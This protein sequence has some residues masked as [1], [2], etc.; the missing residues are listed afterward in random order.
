[1]GNRIVWRNLSLTEHISK[2]LLEKTNK[3]SRKKKKMRRQIYEHLW[4]NGVAMSAFNY[5]Q[6]S[7]RNAW[8]SVN[9]AEK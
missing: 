5:R 1:M 6:W 2:L 7:Y 3:H 4:P 8:Q 9:D